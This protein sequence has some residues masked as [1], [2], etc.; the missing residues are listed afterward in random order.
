MDLSRLANPFG[1][2]E[3]FGTPLGIEF[4]LLGPEVHIEK[5]QVVA[6]GDE[7]F[8]SGRIALLLSVLG[9]EEDAR[10]TQ[11][12]NDCQNFGG[13]T[14]LFMGKEQHLTKRRVQREFRHSPSH[15]CQISG[16]V[17]GAQDPELVQRIHNIVLR[18]W[19]HECK[20]LD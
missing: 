2:D 3:M 5:S 8:L 16:V 13:A 18:W 11:H 7:E 6:F 20:V 14:S 4:I 15:R 17:E 9:S 19:V 12:G 1:V 10:N